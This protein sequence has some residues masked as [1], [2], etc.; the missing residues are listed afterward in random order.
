V[1]KLHAIKKDIT[2]MM[3]LVTSNF[4]GLKKLA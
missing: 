1:P 3:G 4:S 2:T